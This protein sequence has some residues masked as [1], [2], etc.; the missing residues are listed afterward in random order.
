VVSAKGSTPSVRHETAAL[1]DFNPAYVAFGSELGHSAMSVQC[2]VC[3][4]ADTAERRASSR[5]V[6]QPHAPMTIVLAQLLE[7]ARAQARETRRSFQLKRTAKY[8]SNSTCG[9]WTK[10]K[11]GA[12]GELAH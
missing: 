8:R 3:P 2:P 11:A 4:K 10:D 1:R 9:R 7:D 5:S 6:P 12:A